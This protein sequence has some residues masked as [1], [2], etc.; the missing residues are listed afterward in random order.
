MNPLVIKMSINEY[1]LGNARAKAQE[2]F[3]SF[4]RT[5]TIMTGIVSIGPIVLFVLSVLID[6]YLSLLLPIFVTITVLVIRRLFM[7][8]RKKLNNELLKA[9]GYNESFINSIL[10]GEGS[11]LVNILGT[12][13]LRKWFYVLRALNDKGYDLLDSL[14]SKELQGELSNNEVDLARYLLAIRFSSDKLTMSA[15]NRG[16]RII[17][18]GYY[19]LLFSIPAVAKAL[20]FL[21]IHWNPIFI[22][23]IQLLISITLLSF[24]RIVKREFDINANTLMFFTTFILSILM[25]VILLIK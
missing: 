6:P 7:N 13:D 20:Q 4:E 10:T 18:F 3:D 8:F 2:V 17:M 23:A 15:L 22:L 5:L 14:L 19:V 11:I 12:D 21:G 16:L 9:M 24:L 25:D 1:L